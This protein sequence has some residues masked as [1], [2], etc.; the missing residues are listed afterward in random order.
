VSF[1]RPGA[2]PW[3]CE[4]YIYPDL[5]RD[6][7]SGKIQLPDFQRG[8]VWKDEDIRSLLSGKFTH[9]FCFTEVKRIRPLRKY[10]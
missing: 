2:L 3:W 7:V 8:W 4:P 6:T 10:L 5:L 9:R 1:G